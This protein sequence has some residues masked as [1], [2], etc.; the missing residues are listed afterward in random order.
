MD[1]SELLQDFELFLKNTGN[2]Q[3]FVTW[4][5]DRGSTPEDYGF[6]LEEEDDEI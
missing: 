5:D 3:L 4:L 2:W 6:G 1:K